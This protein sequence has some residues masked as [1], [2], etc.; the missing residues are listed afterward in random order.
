MV[1]DY[2]ERN[3]NYTD[4]YK[5]GDTESDNS[6]SGCCDSLITSLL[7]VP[8]SKSLFKQIKIFLQHS[9]NSEAFTSEL[10]EMFVTTCI[11]LCLASSNIQPNTSV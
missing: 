10:L 8:E 7:K 9:S 2:N 6:K 5:S 11:M 1:Q 4:H 3:S